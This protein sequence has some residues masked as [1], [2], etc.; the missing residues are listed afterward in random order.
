MC[1]VPWT[2]IKNSTKYSNSLKVVTENIHIVG[3]HQLTE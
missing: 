1:N 2:L 3:C